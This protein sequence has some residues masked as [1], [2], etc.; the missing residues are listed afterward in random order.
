MENKETFNFIANEYE[1]F[2]PTY[3]DEM[4]DDI[5]YYSNAEKKDSI[6]EIGC[7]SPFKLAVSGTALHFINPKFGY[8]RVWEL[9]EDSGSIGFFW[10][11]HVPK[12]DEIHNEIRTHYK[13]LAPQLDDSKLQTPEEAI[14]ERRTLTENSG[15]FSNIIVKE[16]NQVLSYTSGD[17]I[18][19]LNTNSKHRQLSESVRYSLLNRIKNSI[20][21][22]GGYIYKDHRVALFLGK[23]LT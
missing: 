8:R 2:R 12:Y 14:N 20:D 3:P 23:K 10:T 6:L 17:Y 5:F 16:Y 15:L 4:F 7:G 11:I 22:S 18:S 1:R 19:L 21:R 9:L 13:E